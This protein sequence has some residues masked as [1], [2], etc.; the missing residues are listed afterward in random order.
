MQPFTATVVD[1]TGNETDEQCK[2]IA[3]RMFC[4]AHPVEAYQYN[5]EGFW[6]YLHAIYPNVTREQMAAGMKECEAL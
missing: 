6:Q 2:N 4:T 1:L 5:P 3:W